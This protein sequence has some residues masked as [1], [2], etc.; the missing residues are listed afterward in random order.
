MVTE[1][2]NYDNSGSASG[3]EMGNS[4]QVSTPNGSGILSKISGRL[5]YRQV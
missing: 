1:E 2:R 4:S 5:M 3:L